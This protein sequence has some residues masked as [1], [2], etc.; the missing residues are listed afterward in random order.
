MQMTRIRARTPAEGQIHNKSPHRRGAPPLRAPFAREHLRSDARLEQED[1][2]DELED[3]RGDE[4]TARHEKAAGGDDDFQRRAIEE[5]KCTLS[6]KQAHG[7]EDA[8]L[9]RFSTAP[10]LEKTTYSPLQ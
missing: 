6:V 3:P 10:P 9:A 1:G 5:S 4:N 8:D 7:V 2:N